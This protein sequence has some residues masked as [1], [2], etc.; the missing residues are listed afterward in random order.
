[1]NDYKENMSYPI[2]L[3]LGMQRYSATMNVYTANQSSTLYRSFFAGYKIL[4]KNL[5]PQFI[6]NVIRSYRAG[7]IDKGPIDHVGG[8]MHVLDNYA[9]YLH[10]KRVIVFYLNSHNKDSRH[11]NDVSFNDWSQSV[12]R[13]DFSVEFIDLDLQDNHFFDIDGHVNKN[14]NAEIARRLYLVLERNEIH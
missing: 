7:S 13:A 2:D 1:M 11:I 4:A 12:T 8:V 9:D 10:G 5:L 6:V 14:G 3:E